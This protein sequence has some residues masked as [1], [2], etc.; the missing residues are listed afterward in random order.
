MELP[1]LEKRLLDGISP[2]TPTISDFRY[3]IKPIENAPK[4]GVFWVFGKHLTIKE[5]TRKSKITLFGGANSESN[6]YK[7]V[8]RTQLLH[9]D[10]FLIFWSWLSLFVK[11]VSM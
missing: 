6:G 5:R 9:G 3:M 10:H 1:I 2:K 7:K 11:C 8:G 4:T